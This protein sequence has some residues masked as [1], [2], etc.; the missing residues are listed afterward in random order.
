MIMCSLARGGGNIF[1]IEDGDGMFLQN[2]DR[3]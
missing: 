1:R 2:V 3:V